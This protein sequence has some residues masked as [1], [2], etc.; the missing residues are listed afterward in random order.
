MTWL[1][2]ACGRHALEPVAHQ[3]RLRR[4]DRRADREP[5]GVRDR[6]SCSR[7][8]HCPQ[9][10]RRSASRRC[11]A[12]ERRRR[13]VGQDDVVQ[14]HAEVLRAP[15]ADVGDRDLDRLAGVARR[16]RSTTAAS[17]AS[18]PDAAFHV[19]PDVPFAVHVGGVPGVERLV[20]LE[21]RV[22]LEPARRAALAR[23]LARVP[24]GIR[25]RRP[26]AAARRPRLDG[27]E[28]PVLLGVVRRPERQVAAA[29]RHRDLAREP[30]VGHVGDLRVHVLV[31]RVRI[32]RS[33][34]LVPARR[35]PA[36]ELRVLVAPAGGRWSSRTTSSCP[37]CS[38]PSGPLKP[39]RQPVER[40]V[41]ADDGERLVVRVDAVVDDLRSCRRTSTRARR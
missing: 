21:E 18:C 28:V 22:Q 27:E 39:P 23:V 19:R 16:D 37:G 30:L 11:R 2:F 26:V 17:P 34:G 32:E 20:V 4:R 15:V 29:G 3:D 8:R 13:A 25:Q 36:R 6:A 9:A 1:R 7:S 12:L 24:V 38:A 10:A 31:A 33:A 35:R 41:D 5:A 14:E 40:V